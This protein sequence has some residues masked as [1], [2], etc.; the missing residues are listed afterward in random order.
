MS[1]DDWFRN[2]AWNDEIASRFEAKLK[3]ARQKGQYIRIQACTLAQEH[4]EI[5]L[6]LLEKYFAQ[7]DRFDEASAHCGRATALIALGRLDD[8]VA[9]YEEALAAEVRLPS[10]ITGAGLELPYLVAVARLAGQYDRALN[11][12]GTSRKLLV[13]P[14]ELFKWNAAHALIAGARGRLAEARDFARNALEAASKDHS[15]FRYHAKLGLVSQEQS[16]VLRR[17]RVYCDS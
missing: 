2:T 6:Q 11:V 13:F 16:D 17:L 8:A 14:L 1:R 5:A 7:E 10:Y 9:A 4:P 3:R 12:L 15:G